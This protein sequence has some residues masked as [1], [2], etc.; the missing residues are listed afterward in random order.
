M[1]NG[2]CP[3]CDS[4]EVYKIDFAPLQAGGSFVVLYNPGANDLQLEVY[5]CAQCGHME[6]NVA[7]KHMSRIPA[8]IKSD[9][10]QKV[11]S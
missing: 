11:S 2:K 9:K 5:L 3:S 7:E 4:A 6:V 1:K 8:L 10:W